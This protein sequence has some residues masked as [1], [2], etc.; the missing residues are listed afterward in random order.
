MKL[1]D[2]LALYNLSVHK[3]CRYHNIC[4]ESIYAY[5]KGRI[6]RSDVSKA[7]VRA[8]R[9]EVSLEDFGLSKKITTR[10]KPKKQKPRKEKGWHEK[11]MIAQSM[12]PFEAFEIAHHKGRS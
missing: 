10:S 6:P 5:L 8:T 1:K 4:R 12:S 11:I 9:G 7:I 2:W 3:F